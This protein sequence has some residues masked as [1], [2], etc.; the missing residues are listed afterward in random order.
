[1]ERARK[2]AFALAALVPAA[3][4]SVPASA[5]I[6]L[7]GYYAPV[8][9]EDV[10]ERIPGPDAGDYLGLPINEAARSRGDTWNGSLLT[11]PERQCIPHPS[12]YGWRGV[13]NLRIWET[14]DLVTQQLV[15]LDAYIVW[16]TQHREIWMDGRPHPPESAPHSWQGF[17]TGKWE[18]DVLHVHTTHLKPGWIRRNGLALSDKA[19]LDER[20]FLHEGMLNHVMM[21]SDPVY[22]TEPM[23][24]TNLWGP[25]PYLDMAPYPCR[26]AVEIPR[27]KGVIPH[28]GFNDG[29][30]SAEFAA[31]FRLPLA[32]ARGGAETALPE[33]MDTHPQPAAPVKAARR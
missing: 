5:T 32:A 10:D 23:V 3:M 31:G 2:L 16:E 18:G 6:D 1:M 7:S 21:V 26:P 20:F 22:L 29:S 24:K 14:R 17:S 15:K 27:E 30:A 19:T 4:L 13:G 11:L 33:F 8:M 12:T 25:R 28:N 9:H